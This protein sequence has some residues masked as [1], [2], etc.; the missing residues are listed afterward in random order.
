MDPYKVEFIVQ[1]YY[2]YKEM[3]SAL[4]GSTLPC[5]QERFNSHNGNAY[6]QRYTWSCLKYLT[7][8]IFI[9]F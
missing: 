3:W 5:Q 1:G 8:A 6:R 4:V 9:H 7:N 2:T